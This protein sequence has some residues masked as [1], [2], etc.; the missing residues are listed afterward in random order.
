MAPLA[1]FGQR[2]LAR[3]IDTVVLLAVVV[4]VSWAVMGDDVRHGTDE[5]L[6]RR[7]LVGIVGY[8]LYFA[9]EGAMTAARGQTLGKMAL[10]IRAARL[11]DGAVPGPAG[12]TRAAVYVLPAVLSVILV[13][14]LFW[15]VNSLWCTWDRPFRQCLHDKAARTVV[16]AAY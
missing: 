9:I 5:T 4:V 6:G 8:L 13:G 7:A 10:R 3:L 11:V 14:P 12:W 1:G 2:F 16:V 15:V